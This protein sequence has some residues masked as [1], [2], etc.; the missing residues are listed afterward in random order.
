MTAARSM[1]YSVG[2]GIL[3]PLAWFGAYRIFP[4]PVNHAMS[5]PWVGDAVLLL[6]P[7]SILLL[8]DP[9]E[10]SLILPIISVALNAVLYGAIGWLV[11][12]GWNRQRLILPVVA[13]GVLSGW[14]VLLRWYVGV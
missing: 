1:L 11:W 12:I 7:S 5:T 10:V 3:L 2:A 9:D 13:V 4:E 14:Y 8:G 6:W